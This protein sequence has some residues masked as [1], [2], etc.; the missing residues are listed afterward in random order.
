M[1]MGSRVTEQL[2]QG[3]LYL[4]VVATLQHAIE[5][6]AYSP[7]ER[8]P[9]ER[10]LAV[11]LGVSRPV[12]RE[13]IAVL[14][15]RGLVEA[16][17]GA[18]VFVQSIR[19][20]SQLEARSAANP[21]EIIEAQRIMSGEVAALAAV[22]IAD[23]QLSLLS[24]LLLRL[25]EQAT[26]PAVREVVQRTFHISL[27]QCA[28]NDAIVQTIEALWD[29]RL[30]S[31]LCRYYFHR[32]SEVGGDEL[33]NEHRSILAALEDRD[34]ES[35]RLATQAHF[36]SAMTR[37]LMVTEEDLRERERFGAEERHLKYAR[38]AGVC[39]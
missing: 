13:A 25:A 39:V 2:K 3:R 38:R 26:D 29:M 23:Q 34:P 1:K 21:F 27:A 9:S 8:L 32:V 16:R 4:S 28:G 10:E 18:G 7:G 11:Q 17:H 12:L 31:P 35:A 15:L 33:E 6:G 5:A 36:T 20:R 22:S 24:G 37:L 30:S 14:Q 19:E